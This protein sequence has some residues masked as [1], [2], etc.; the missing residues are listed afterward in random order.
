[1]VMRNILKFSGIVLTLLGVISLIVRQSKG[2]TSNYLLVVGLG[3]MILGLLFYIVVN[4]I[5][6]D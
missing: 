5:V 4:K 6:E 3:C 2:E 1:M